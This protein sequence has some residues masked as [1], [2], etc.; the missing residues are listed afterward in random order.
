MRGEMVTPTASRTAKRMLVMGRRR[1]RAP[2]IATNTF[3]TRALPSSETAPT[4]RPRSCPSKRRRYGNFGKRLPLEGPPLLSAKP[5]DPYSLLPSFSLLPLVQ[6]YRPSLCPL[7]SPLS[8]LCSFR[9]LSARTHSRS[10]SN[11]PWFGASKHHNRDVDSTYFRTS[12]THNGTDQPTRRP[13]LCV[14]CPCRPP[15]RPQT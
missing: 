5:P 14:R 9:S 13:R 6:T 1:Y 12:I 8:I 3:S 11:S 4:S 10:F 7:L 2:Q 15:A